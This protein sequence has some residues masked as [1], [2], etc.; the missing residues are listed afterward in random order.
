[1]KVLARAANL[2]IARGAFQAA[3]KM[4]PGE[5]IELRRMPASWSGAGP[6]RSVG[7]N[8]GNLRKLLIYQ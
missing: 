7:Q 2:P 6:K 4:Y 3:V 1:M 5:A 8:V